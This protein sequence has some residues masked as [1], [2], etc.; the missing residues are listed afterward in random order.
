MVDG[1]GMI[2]KE[3]YRQIVKG[4]STRHDLPYVDGD[5]AVVAAVLATDE[6][7]AEVVDPQGRTDWG[8]LEKWSARE[9]NKVMRRVSKMSRPILL[10][11]FDGV[12]YD[13]KDGW[14]RE[15]LNRFT[16]HL[17]NRSQ[18]GQAEHTAHKGD[19]AGRFWDRIRDQGLC[20]PT[21]P[22]P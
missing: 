10:V 21:G 2:R 13:D 14:H 15:R 16:F 6:T 12:L 1:S 17:L 22:T 11:A 18:S 7:A 3:R 8:I 20:I 5:L 4:R 9:S 19:K